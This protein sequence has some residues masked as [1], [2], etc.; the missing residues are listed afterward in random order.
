MGSILGLII[1]FILG[2][3]L[4]VTGAMK[5]TEHRTG[6]EA[7]Q[8]IERCELKLP[9]NENC[10][11]IAVPESKKDKKLSFNPDGFN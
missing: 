10:I 6:V 8:S 7:L 3:T 2:I 9:R 4:A 5:T 1:G 11:I